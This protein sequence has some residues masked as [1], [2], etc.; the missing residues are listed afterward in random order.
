MPNVII[1]ANFGLEKLRGSGYT[2]GQILGFPIKR[3]VT[4]T[5]VLHYRAA[6]DGQRFL[7]NVF[8]RF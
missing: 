7:F 8:K 6:Y 1:C 3:L 2:R 5:T 4:L